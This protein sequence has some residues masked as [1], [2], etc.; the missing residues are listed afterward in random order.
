SAT[1]SP[2]SDSELGDLAHLGGPSP[3]LWLHLESIPSRHHKRHALVWGNASLHP[4]LCRMAGCPHQRSH[5]ATPPAAARHLQ[6]WD[7]AHCKGHFGSPADEISGESLYEAHLHFWWDW[8]N[9]SCFSFSCRS[10][11]GAAQNG[12]G[13]VYDHYAIA[14]IG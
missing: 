8:F 1:E 9:V 10:R 5:R 13:R 11:H 14:S 7:R 2:E 3:R 4:H 6:V 12:L